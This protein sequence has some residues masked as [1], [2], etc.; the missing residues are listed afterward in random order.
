M[1]ELVVVLMSAAVLAALNRRLRMWKTAAIQAWDAYRELERRTR[2]DRELEALLEV[3]VDLEN[4]RSWEEV[5]QWMDSRC[6]E[7]LG[8]EWVEDDGSYYVCGRDPG[9]SGPH[10]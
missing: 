1:T 3:D 8:V 5:Q 7:P 6:N 4:A 10:M 2:F 9:H